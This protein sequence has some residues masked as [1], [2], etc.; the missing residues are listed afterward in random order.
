MLLS[1]ANPTERLSSP[2]LLEPQRPCTMNGPS[3][4]TLSRVRA[5]QCR[6]ECWN[7]HKRRKMLLLKPWHQMKEANRMET[8]S[9]TNQIG[10]DLENRQPFRLGNQ[11]WAH[12]LMVESC[13]ST[14]WVCL[15]GLAGSAY[16]HYTW[17]ELACEAKEKESSSCLLTC[18]RPRV[19][20]QAC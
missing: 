18:R 6:T 2:N 14:S 17:M 3:Q 20:S 8:S 5:E 10:E 15:L 9:P 1:L 11:A 7:T 13:V 4:E 16:S 12:T 19:E